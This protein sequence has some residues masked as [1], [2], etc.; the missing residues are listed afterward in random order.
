MVVNIF[1]EMSVVHTQLAH[2]TLQSAVLTCSQPVTLHLTV[3]VGNL[4]ILVQLPKSSAKQV[5][6]R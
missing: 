6:V 1:H 4:L 5:Q 3:L 2:S